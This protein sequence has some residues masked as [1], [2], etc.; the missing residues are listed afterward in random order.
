MLIFAGLMMIPNAQLL[1][2][3]AKLRNLSL[4]VLAM[5]AGCTGAA[6][7][8][9]WGGVSKAW[10]GAR[11][12]LR[13]L[14]KGQWL[15]RLLDSCRYFGQHPGLI[16]RTL[17]ISMILNAVCVIQLWIIAWGL[18]LT[19]NPIALFVIVPMIIC[20]SA[21]PI[22]PSGLGVRESLF[23]VMLTDVSIHVDPTRALSLSLLAYFGSLI[24]SVIGGVVYMAFKQKHHLAEAELGDKAEPEESVSSGK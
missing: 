7:L 16:L 1:F 20:I 24:W 18:N 23:V 6:A 12:W 14:P 2:E 5:L 8:A 19:I 3:H 4:F 21:L 10:G 15:E 11:V 17:L 22:T 13:R 9:F